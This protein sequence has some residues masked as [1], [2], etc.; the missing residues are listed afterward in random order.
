[1]GK[2]DLAIEN[3]TKV[4]EIDDYHVNAIFSRAACY[5]LNGDYQKA[6]EDYHNALDKDQTKTKKFEKTDKSN[7]DLKNN[8]STFSNKKSM[9]IQK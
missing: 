4:I 8:Y 7:I 9:S 3:F 1:M 2:I 6:I 5:N